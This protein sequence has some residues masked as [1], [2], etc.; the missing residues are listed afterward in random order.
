MLVMAIRINKPFALVINSGFLTVAGWLFYNKGTRTSY[1]LFAMAIA[2]LA[3]GIYRFIRL[4][5]E[6]NSV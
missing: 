2:F 6:A 4:R 1:V 5:R 3:I